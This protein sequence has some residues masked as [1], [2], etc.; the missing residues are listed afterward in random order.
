MQKVVQSVSP[1]LPGKGTTM[2]QESPHERTGQEASSAA[3]PA[4]TEPPSAVQD[5]RNGNSLP[6]DVTLAPEPRDLDHLQTL[7][8]AW[9]RT[10]DWPASQTYL[11]T[12]PELL[13]E[14]AEQVL[15]TLTSLQSNQRIQELLS[16]HQ[17]LL[18]TAR[19][20]G[21]EPA[22]EPL[23]HR[24][25]ETDSAAIAEEDLLRQVEEWISTPSWEHSQAYLE[26]HPGLLTS[27]AETLLAMRYQTQQTD[28][29]SA[30]IVQHLHLQRTAREQGIAAAY[31][32]HLDPVALNDAG[33][34]LWQQYQAEGQIETLN[35]ALEYFQ[36]SLVLTPSDSPDYPTRL[37]NLGVGLRDRYRRMGDLADLEAALTAFQ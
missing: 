27:A 20:Y 12:H 33:I 14:G 25:E 28:Q 31:R 5:A 30:T 36:E 4:G 37:N 18:Q 13:T 22:Y 26:A 1:E 35:R 11:Q 8:L 3:S 29:A 19:Q 32:L 16:L 17:Q 15:A 2:Q 24:E 34:R 23:L 9:I 7:L 10:P 6:T 21:V